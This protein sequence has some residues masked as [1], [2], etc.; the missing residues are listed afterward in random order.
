M[1]N[2]KILCCLLCFLSFLTN[3]IAQE[4]WFSKP[5]SDRPANY[6]IS[7]QLDAEQK[8]IHAKELINWK[9]L[10]ADTIKNLQFHLYLNA[11]KNTQSTFM[12][13]AG[14]L[15]RGTNTAL[16][17]EEDWSWIH[18]D[19]I[20]DDK[21]NDLI[22]F[23]EYVQPDDENEEDRTVIQLNLPEPVLPFSEIN[24]NLDWTSKIPR[25][26]V[27]TGFSRNYFLNVQWYPKLGVYEPAGMRFSEKGNWN[28][29]QYHSSTE[30]YGDFGNYKVDLTVPENFK[31][32]ATGTL[33]KEEE[34][35]DQ[36]TYYFH[37][38]DVID[39]G[40]VASPEFQIIE[41]QWKHVNIKLL[42]IPEYTCCTDRYLQSAKY[43]LEYFE[44]HLAIYPFPTLTIVVPPFHGINSGGMEYPTF[45]TAPGTYAWPTHI[46]S[47]EYFVAHEFVHQYFMMMIST[48]EFEEAWMDE[49]FTSYYKSRI[50]DH[51]Y[52]EK[53][54]VIDY[55]LHMG[56]M[57]FFRS[58][59]QGM[60]NM[61]V[62]NMTH[63]GWQYPNGGYRNLVY[64]KAAVM[65]KTLEGLVGI[66]VMDAILKAYFEQW[67]FKHPCRH[68]FIKVVNE[69]V[70]EKHG[71]KFGENIDWFFEQTLY[72]T[73]VCDYSVAS[74]SNRVVPKEAIGIFEEKG[75]KASRKTLA[76]NQNHIYNSKVIL[77]RLGELKFPVEVIVHFENG[78]Q[79]LEH[80][81][82]Q[83]RAHNFQYEGNHKIDWVQIDP[84]QQIYMDINFLNNSLRTTPKKKTAWKYITEFVV[85]VQSALQGISFFI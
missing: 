25:V 61:K 59:Y 14:G 48:N 44:E 49:G 77:N 71:D 54:S 23:L 10:S 57:E 75:T 55:R 41:E 22:Q 80:W 72:G 37:A 20:Q 13:E 7:A 65:L 39:F 4:T 36:K 40:W 73:G 43:C 42:I 81:D 52:G 8:R 3:L 21:G 27:R 6:E 58:R 30:Y 34:K 53:T 2:W 12:K 18:I 9:N 16:L 66:E 83:A 1:N 70:K 51:Y 26:R 38:E 67:S 74:I 47:P 56:A 11:F 5:L 32:G 33:Y 82:G 68:D 28:C 35:G 78:D 63:P 84:K 46:R 19:H 62:D 64:A 31:V 60:S 29:H 69:V 15:L 50:L 45:I 76:E 85:R 24:L 79:K 17:K